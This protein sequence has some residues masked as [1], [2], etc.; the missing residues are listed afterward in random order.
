MSEPE[1]PVFIHEDN[2]GMIEIL[3]LDS[4]DHCRRQM[5]Q[6]RRHAEQH[7]DPSGYGW[8]KLFVIRRSPRSLESLGLSPD[9]VDRVL[10]PE[11]MRRDVVTGY[12]SRGEPAPRTRAY[13]LGGFSNLFVRWTKRET[14]SMI[15]LTVGPLGPSPT[16]VG[17][18]PHLTRLAPLLLVDWQTNNIVDLSNPA[19]LQAWYGLYDQDKE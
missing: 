6:K 4:M 1:K 15:W 8:S 11:L 12:T 13:T 3:P 14:V 2:V 19:A 5:G 17:C 16:I 18:L 9:S 7:R 10:P